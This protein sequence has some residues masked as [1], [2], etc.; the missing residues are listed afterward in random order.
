[1]TS[2]VCFRPTRRTLV[3]TA[4]WSVPVVSMASMAPAFASSPCD[5]LTDQVLDWDGTKTVY[6]RSSPVSASAMFDPDGVGPI[7][8]LSLTIAASY[9]GKMQAGSETSNANALQVAPSIGGLGVSGL[10]LE[11]ATLSKTPQG[12]SDSGTYTFTFTRPVT[13]LRF[14]YTDIDSASGDFWDYLEPSPGFS[15]VSQGGGVATDFNG[16]GGAQRFFGK[17]S[18]A[19]VDNTTG[20]S[21]N[22]ALSYAG[23]VSSFSLTYWNGAASFANKVDSN[24]IVY[25]SDMTFDYDPC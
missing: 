11:Q 13:N 15:V 18:S 9:S 24:Q 2:T 12:R 25:I 6:T 21:G 14:T 5:P 3:R 22:L 10:G 8:I 16:T 4:A 19:A 7:P 1:M 23:P 17:T 20:S